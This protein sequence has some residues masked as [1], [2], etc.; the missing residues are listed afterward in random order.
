MR[1]NNHLAQGKLLYLMS[2]NNHNN[3]RLSISESKYYRW[4][5]FDNTVQSI[6]SLRQPDALT[7]PHQIALMLP[8]LFFK[9][10]EVTEVGLGGGNI[11]RFLHSLCNQ[12]NFNSI[13]KSDTVI[14]AFKQFFNPQNIH[15]NIEQG[16][17]SLSDTHNLNSY[18]AINSQWLLIDI[19]QQ[20][21]D[22]LKQP[23]NVFK[24]LIGVIKEH[25]CLS[26]NIPLLGEKHLKQELVSLL[27]LLAHHQAY[28]FKIPR[29]KNIVLHLIP[30][31]YVKEY[32]SNFIYNSFN[33][34]LDNFTADHANNFP[35][36]VIDSKIENNKTIE[37]SYLSNLIFKRWSG[38]WQ[39]G[40]K[41]G[42]KIE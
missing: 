17:P 16:S 21:D 8:L 5:S 2:N 40:F 33:N 23:L 37:N 15:F 35:E 22:T 30:N 25:R 36:N 18:L 39:L 27:P 14:H 1:L 19:Y 4:L 41:C 6:M 26:I 38:F 32:G 42:S 12:I 34:H 20:N 31:E 13:E 3:D 7:M 28:Y 24:N 10:T 9:P 29:Y 11:A